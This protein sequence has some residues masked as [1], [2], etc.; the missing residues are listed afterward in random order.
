[1]KSTKIEEHPVLLKG[2]FWE[3]V[4]LETIWSVLSILNGC[5]LSTC[6]RQS[7]LVTQ[8]LVS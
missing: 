7:L 1:M 5:F 8:V 6:I 3:E 4:A 2:Y